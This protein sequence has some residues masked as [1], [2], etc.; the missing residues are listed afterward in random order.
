M[1][2]S[3]VPA[4]RRCVPGCATLLSIA[5]VL[6]ACRASAAGASSHRRQGVAVQV[7]VVG[8][9]G[10]V[11]SG[12]RSVLA[13]AAHVRLGGRGCAVAAATPLA[14]LIA[15]RD[16]GG[17]AFALRDYGHCDASPA[18]SSQLFVSAV[19][20]QRNSA[21]NGW[22]YEVNGIAGSA[23]A[24][25][26]SGPLGNGRRLGAGAKVL[27]FY[28]QMGAQGCQRTLTVAPQTRTVA[29]GAPLTVSVSGSNERSSSTPVADA[30]VTLGPSRASTED[31]G[32]A[33]VAAPTIPGS[34]EL[35]A[36]APGTVPSFPVAVQVR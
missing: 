22:V 31:D 2:A 20:G 30:A 11:L 35:S 6:L 24:A 4:R 7:M 18:D 15:L 25:D 12:A 17:P 29:A 14:A 16:V 32:I 1:S 10:V 27:W 19:G 8:K 9:G 23:G 36:T 28:C 26:P 13:G 33:V 3:A 21:E 5:L 34:Y